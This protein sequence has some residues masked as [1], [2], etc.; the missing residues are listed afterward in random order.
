MRLA[1]AERW[2]DGLINRERQPRV[3]YSRFGLEAI[4]SLLGRIGNPERGLSVV[5]IAGSKGK[6]STALL[7]EAL[8]LGLGESV[9]TFTSPHL[10]RWTE[11]FRIDGRE[12]EGD[13]LAR[14]V[15]RIRPHVDAM[16]AEDSELWP[17]FFDATTAA[18]FVLFA[19]AGVDRVV[20]EVGLGGRLDSTNSVTPAVTCVTSIEYEHTDKLGNTLA[21]IAGEKAGILKPGVPCVIGCLPAEA[22]KVI[23]ERAALLDVRLE[24]LSEQTIAETGHYRFGDGF[25]FSAPLAVSGDHQRGNAAVAV[26]AVRAL[27]VHDD[28]RIAGAARDAFAKVSLPGRVE[29]VERDPWVIID[30]AHTRESVRALAAF[31]SGLEVRSRHFVLSVSIDKALDPMLELLLPM[32]H[33]LTITRA[34]PVRG[35]APEEVARRVGLQA[36]EIELHLADDPAQAIREA[37]ESLAPGALLCVVGSVYLAGIARRELVGS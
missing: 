27:R 35:L 31:V 6:G 19:E 7:A 32:A 14:A 4:E 2:L 11:R 12:V 15:D 20:L 28:D 25:S 22:V 1:E 10:E 17:S 18:A 24:R 37:R 34:D 9:G 36:T 30:G 29:I 23:E 33:E 5:H 13:V 16:R 21:E 26:A 8:L 3:S